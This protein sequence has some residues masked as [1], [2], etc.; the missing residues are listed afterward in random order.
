MYRT[1]LTF[2][3]CC[4]GIMNKSVRVAALAID[5]SAEAFLD[6]KYVLCQEESDRLRD[7]ASRALPAFMGL[8]CIC[9]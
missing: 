4:H 6:A 5:C 7:A 2:N 1:S 8:D 3:Y 9:E